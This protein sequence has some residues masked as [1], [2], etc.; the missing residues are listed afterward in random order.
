MR[1]TTTR[2]LSL[3]VVGFLCLNVGAFFCLAHC[4]KN[5]MAASASHCPLKNDPSSHCHHS[6]PA[7]ENPDTTSFVGDSVTCCVL[8]IGVF[9]APL[10]KKAGS[11]TAMLVETS[12]EQVVFAPVSLGAS[13]QIPKF[14][15]RPPPNDTRF[16]R[17][18]NQVFRI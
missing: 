9:A 15:Y 12:V 14:Y 18:R 3:F 5:V 11:V 10:E 7:K 8:P 2:L 6:R 1:H 13:R 16:E 17:V 4:N